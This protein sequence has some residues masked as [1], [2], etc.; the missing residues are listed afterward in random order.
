[1]PASQSQRQIENLGIRAAGPDQA[2]TALS[3]GNQQK[4]M[5]ARWLLCQPKIL[6]LDEP[7]VGIDVGAK[8]EIYALVRRLAAQGIGILLVSSE[9]PEVLTL[10]DRILVMHH[11]ALIGSLTSGEAS[12]E[13]IMQ[14]I[15]GS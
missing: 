13:K 11:G 15:H 1:M 12:E 2:I 5:L 8:A 9:L 10:S 3:G 4:V 14:L 6:V 7:T